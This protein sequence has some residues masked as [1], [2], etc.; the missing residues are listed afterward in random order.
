M[1][2]PPAFAKATARSDV[3]LAKSERADRH[4]LLWDGRC[5]FCQRCVTWLMR[6]R[7]AE[8]FQPLPYQTAASPVVTPEIRRAS[9][10]AMHVLSTDGRVLK[11]GR[12]SLFI[13]EQLGWRWTARVL[14]RPPF[15]WFV[16]LA[17]K[18]VAANRN[19]ISRLLPN[20]AATCALDSDDNL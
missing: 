13:L 20:T 3:A 17:Y 8:S 16:E 5:G 18:L 4:L 2:E 14:S 19:R 1:S 7:G 6:Q 15:V 10:H 12:A 11:A 9:A